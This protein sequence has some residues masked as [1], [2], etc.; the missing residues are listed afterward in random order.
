MKYQELDNNLKEKLIDLSKEFNLSILILFGSRQNGKFKQDSDWDFAYYPN[1]NFSNDDDIKLF[2]K[3]MKILKFEKI[4][5][6]NLRKSN[7]L[8]VINNIFQTGTLIYEKTQGLFKTKKWSAWID[9]QDFKK[10]YDIQKE[11]TKNELLLMI[12]D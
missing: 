5:L 10:Y 11:L 2:E 1:D 9:Y 7:Q 6:L 8:N 3:L 4:D 12:K